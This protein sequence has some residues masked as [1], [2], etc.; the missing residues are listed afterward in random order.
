MKKNELKNARKVGERK[1]LRG[2]VS[3]FLNAHNKWQVRFNL[4]DTFGDVVELLRRGLD[5]KYDLSGS[6]ESGELCGV[7]AGCS[8][9]VDNAVS[10]ELTEEQADKVRKLLTDGKWW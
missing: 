6:L 7:F 2:S 3:L 10:E 5:K 8:F 9:D 1:T 4:D